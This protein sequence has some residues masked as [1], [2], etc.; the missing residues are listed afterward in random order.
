MPQSARLSVGEGVQSLFGQCPN[1]GA[2]NRNGA[3]LT[4]SPLLHIQVR[5]KVQQKRSHIAVRKHF[6]NFVTSQESWARAMAK[7]KFVFSC[8]IAAW[9]DTKFH[10]CDYS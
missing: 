8:V 7:F 4:S 2:A 5:T 6:H 1:R 3:S 10:V 9:M